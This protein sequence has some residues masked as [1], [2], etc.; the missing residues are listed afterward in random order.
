MIGEDNEYQVEARKKGTKPGLDWMK[1]NW[2]SQV[3]ANQYQIRKINIEQWN[4]MKTVQKLSYLSQL[5]E[6]NKEA[7]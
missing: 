2:I 5:T 4:S 1:E 6:L 7:F 3:A